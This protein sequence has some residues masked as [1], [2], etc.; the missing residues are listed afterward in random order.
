MSRLFTPIEIQR[1]P[2]I[3]FG[4]GV[5]R[6]VG[7]FASATALQRPLVVVGRLQCRARRCA[8]PPG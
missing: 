6:R 7:A 1:P 5:V 2:S 8:R 3:Q 4:P